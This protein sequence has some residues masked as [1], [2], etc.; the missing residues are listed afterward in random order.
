MSKKNTIRC[1]EYW[2]RMHVFVDGNVYP[3]CYSKPGVSSMGN[4]NE[5][6]L[7]EIWNGETAQEHRRRIIEGRFEE[8]CW[9]WCPVLHDGSLSEEKLKIK[10]GPSAFV[11]NQ[12]LSRKEISE[13]KVVLESVP[14]YHRF[15]PSLRCNLR[16]I[17][18]F[19]NRNDTR[20]LPKSYYRDLNKWLAYAETINL[21]GESLF[22]VTPA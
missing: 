22:A 13:Q 4:V 14:Q 16:C 8:V 9:D 12:E 18:C 21:Q 2:K 5:A 19:Q 1:T 10:S 15:I 20:E 17:M 11:A 6:S 3:C 7:E